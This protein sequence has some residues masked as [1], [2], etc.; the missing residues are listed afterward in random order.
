MSYF[1][2]MPERSTIRAILVDDEKSSLESLAFELNA[3]CPEVEI[4]GSTCSPHE[5][6]AMIEREKPD[7][8]FLDIGM[9]EMDGFELLQQFETIEFDVVFVTAYDEYAVKA[10]EFNALDYLLKPVLHAKLMAAIEKVSNRH[11]HLFERS[12]LDAL[13]TNLQIKQ[14]PVLQNIA[15]PTGDGFEFVP[16]AEIEYLQADNNYCWVHLASGKKYLICKTLKQMEAMIGLPQYFRVHKSFNVNL[17][18]VSRYIRGQGGYLIMHNK[19][20]IPVSRAKKDE[21]MRVLQI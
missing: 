2:K 9:P 7:V 21:L 12:K 5:G 20:R 14:D 13:L 15:L 10:F 18:H 4:V 8:V 1:Y 11:Q 3:Y 17:N 6:I 16:L 19:A